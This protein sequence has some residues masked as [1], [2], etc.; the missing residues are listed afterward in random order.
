M[1]VVIS[2]IGMDWE[3][4]SVHMED[5]RGK[6]STPTWEEMAF[7]KFLFWDEEEP[8]MQLHPPRSTYINNHRNVLHMWKPIGQ[9]IPLPPSILVGIK[10]ISPEQM[11]NMRGVSPVEIERH[12]A[13]L[14][15]KRHRHSRK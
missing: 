10:G 6:E 11:E 7:I 3:H 9:E 4:I 14:G 15:H 2:S 12:L 5:S 8:V 13:H 1:A